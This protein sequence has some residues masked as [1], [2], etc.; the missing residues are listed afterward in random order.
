[1]TRFEMPFP[2]ELLNI[3]RIA[4]DGSARFSIDFVRVDFAGK[5]AE[6]TD[7]SV[8]IRQ[9]ISVPDDAKDFGVAYLN[10]EDLRR[11]SKIIDG[12]PL[13]FVLGNKD[14][15]WFAEGAS[16]RGANL[17]IF[18]NHGD[19]DLR[20]PNTG[21][22]YNQPQAPKSVQF[23]LNQSVLAR[24]CKLA[25]VTNEESLKFSVPLGG[26]TQVISATIGIDEGEARFMPMSA[27]DGKPSIEIIE[28][29]VKSIQE[30]EKNDGSE[31]PIA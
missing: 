4:S 15:I 1:M 25:A 9:K 21:Q 24:L 22:I 28:H 23:V 5:M 2:K 12:R 7:G 6:A 13:R 17:R 11:V 14:G 31:E 18:I 19:A 8:I 27:G 29:S 10:R 16:V 30:D 20:W 3:W 26:P